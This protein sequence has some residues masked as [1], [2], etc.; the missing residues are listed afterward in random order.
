MFMLN[1]CAQE[2]EVWFKKSPPKKKEKK[3]IRNNQLDHLYS[4]TNNHEKKCSRNEP[5]TFLD[6]S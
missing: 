4:T 2:H 3:S 5:K 6:D 1:I